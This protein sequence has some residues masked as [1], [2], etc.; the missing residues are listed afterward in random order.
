MD[1][2]RPIDEEERLKAMRRERFSNT[3]GEQ[4]FKQLVTERA[5]RRQQLIEQGAMSNQS[6]LTEARKIVGTCTLM[7]PVFER[8]ERELKKGLVAQEVYPGTLQ[9]DPAR[10][11][12]TFHR[13]AA[14]NEEPLPEDL[15]TPE[16]LIRTLDYLV[17]TIIAQDQ[18]LQSC[19]S[20]VRD[21]TRSI[22][23]DFTIQNIRD[24]H[25]VTACERIAR[26]H[27]VSLHVLCGHKGFAEQQ[28]MEQLRNTLKTLIELY[29]DHRKSGHHCPNESEFY[30]Y[31]IVSHLRDSDAK[32]VA[33]RLPSRVFLA[34]VVQQALKLHRLS[35]SGDALYT[36]QDPGNL[37]AA[38][39]QATQFFRAVASSQTP[40]LL[41]CLAEYQFPSIR[42]AALKAMNT[43]F[44]YQAG[45]EYPTGEFADMLAFDSVD[46][47]R[48]FCRQF[49]VS[50]SER[51][52]KL[53]ERDGRRMVFKDPEQRPQ[54]VHRN[55]RVVG[56]KFHSTPMHAINSNLDQRLLDPSGPVISDGS[57]GLAISASVSAFQLP[58]HAWPARPAIP[59]SNRLSQVAQT[60][61]PVPAFGGGFPRVQASSTGSVFSIPKQAFPTAP[62]A[63][64]FAGNH[65]GKMFSVPSSDSASGFLPQTKQA[66]L[67]NELVSNK[68]AVIPQPS[69][70]GSGFADFGLPGI[71]QKPAVSDSAAPRASIFSIPAL[72]TKSVS[73]PAVLPPT[74]AASL[75]S[76]LGTSAGPVTPAPTPAAPTLAPS[77]PAPAIVWNRPRPR[78]NWTALSNT[79]YDEVLGSLVLEVVKP[80]ALRAK[81]CALVADALAK[82]IADAIV[83][84]TSAFVA[85]EES[86]RC[87]LLTQANAFRR[88]A[89]L[90]GVLQRWSI[91]A[92]ARL[93][94]KALQQHYIDGL[95]ELVDNEYGTAGRYPA[96]HGSGLLYGDVNAEMWHAGAEPLARNPQRSQLSVAG[97]AMPSDFWESSH[98]GRDGFD[99]I[100][101]ALKRYGGP[102]FNAIIDVSGTRESSVLASWLWWQI[103]MTSL[104]TSS[105]NDLPYRTASYSNCLQQLVFREL[106]AA[107]VEDSSELPAAQ[108][109]CQIVVLA[110]EPVGIDDVSINFR[111]TSLGGEIVARV[112]DALD[113]ASRLPASTARRGT[114]ATSILFLFWSSGSK[115][116][117]AT[118]KLV[119]QTASARGI[120]SFAA[121]STL[122]LD[123]SSSK[124]QLA[125][126]LKWVYKHIV[127]AQRE[128]LVR[129]AKAYESICHGMLYSLR[130]VYG[131][132][133]GLLGHYPG[134]CAVSAEI[135][136]KA[137]DSANHYIDMLNALLLLP[138][139]LPELVRYPR[140]SASGVSKEYFSTS[141]YQMDNGFGGSG[142]KL[143]F[144]D[145]I[146]CASIEEILDAETAGHTMQPALSACL[147]ALDFAVKHQLDATQQQIPGDAY[148]DK[149]AIDEA[150]KQ[151][152]LAA[153][154][155]TRKVAELCQ[156]GSTPGDQIGLVSPKAKRPSSTAFSISPALMLFVDTAPSVAS[157][158]GS[159]PSI[160]ALTMQ[161]ATKRHRPVT[162]LKLSKL[163][164]AMARAGEHFNK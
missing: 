154:Q 20:F 66:S 136:N 76:R 89:L 121:I 145:A 106:A 21:R 130:R 149:N 79:L 74:P 16:T 100:R 88:K 62:P 131:C 138:A 43:A 49:S 135:F 153:D 8:E 75:F 155:I 159:M 91:L 156:Q 113:R 114:P 56:A 126:G 152:A 52:V 143:V 59:T 144:A 27:I 147:R 162:S 48:E 6:S 127:L 46:E 116:S 30:A 14:G 25:T 13:S 41:A 117:R 32:R 60:S 40:L 28:D 73:E 112:Q 115:A 39:N 158:P 45:K 3:Q 132:V 120:P 95:D 71:S 161:S 82:D 139:R 23:Q 64:A 99:A 146:V 81:K 69:A 44:P 93:Q 110:S 70:L 55:L 29:D 125:D 38:Q 164:Q 78:I 94:D 7:C 128:S 35:E 140:T 87:V 11:V 33:E 19:H 24:H 92:V 122:A 105:D 9:A 54:R 26:F 160:S 51:G 150:V 63:E 18:T 12:K 85:Y 103:D 157:T 101:R 109:T 31:Y 72:A 124:Q 137:V 142:E 90:R 22:R 61:A 15:R 97:P 53:G 50:V 2:N 151:A 86:Y 1:F 148:V 134:S 65:S 4:R 42:R 58:G 57:S 84:Y 108:H 118:R 141:R 133:T 36:R 77:V 111:A 37:F 129:V 67:A 102:S 96:A 68:A 104:S 17:N 107:R 80:Q 123:I 98:L 10:T 163:Q 5:K 83:N 47:V 34:P 119:E